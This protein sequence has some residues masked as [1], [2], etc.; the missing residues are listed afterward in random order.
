M[1]AINRLVPFRYPSSH[2]GTV[3]LRYDNAAPLAVVIDFGMRDTGEEDEWTVARDVL[4]DGFT[5]FA[6]KGDVRCWNDDFWF[7]LWLSG[8]DQRTGLQRSGIMRLDVDE[9]RLFL[10]DTEDLVPHGAESDV[11]DVELSKL[12]IGGW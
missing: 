6:G 4:A 11:I 9:V 3:V 2:R 7:Y 1:T 12:L 10:I 5:S 8:V